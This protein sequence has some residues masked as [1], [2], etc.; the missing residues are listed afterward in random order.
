L[1][2]YDCP[3]GSTHALID[4]FC[5]L[6]PKFGKNTAKNSFSSAFSRIFSKIWQK[7][8]KRIKRNFPLIDTLCFSTNRINYGMSTVQRAAYKDNPIFNLIYLPPDRNRLKVVQKMLKNDWYF[9]PNFKSQNV[10]GQKFEPEMA[11]HAYVFGLWSK[12]PF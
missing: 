10:S 1:F 2:L 6:L 3:V 7:I 9:F 11:T 12:F 4:T 8:A 5:D